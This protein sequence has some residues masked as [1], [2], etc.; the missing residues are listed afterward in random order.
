MDLP[1]CTDP[2]KTLPYCMNSYMSRPDCI[3]S[4]IT[5]PNC[6]YSYMALFN[7]TDCYMSLPN[8]TVSYIVHLLT[9]TWPSSTV[10]TAC[11][12]LECAPLMAV[13]EDLS[14]EKQRWQRSQGMTL[15]YGWFFLEVI[16]DASLL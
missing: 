6:I 14:T 1:Y 15:L 7:C 10:Q 11:L 9:T 12:S 8:C 16:R 5:L 3:Y 4:Y 13:M 2:Y